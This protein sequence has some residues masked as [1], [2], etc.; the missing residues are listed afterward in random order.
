[1][2]LL[3]FSVLFALLSPG[4]VAQDV[5]QPYFC[6]TPGVELTYS[7]YDGDGDFDGSFSMLVIDCIGDM[8]KGSVKYSHK[9]FDD[10]NKPLFNGKEL[11]MDV[12]LDKGETFSKMYE[13]KKAIKVQDVFS[14]GDASSL[15]L[16]MFVGMK[17]RDGE[18]VVQV[19]NI[20]STVK[21]SNRKVTS[22]DLITTDAG[23]YECFKIEE[24]QTNTV[25]GFSK[26]W[27]VKTWYAKNMGCVKQETYRKGKLISSQIL[28]KYKMI[29]SK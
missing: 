11:I 16:E 27:D 8:T 5:V 26:E 6:A 14:K 24:H 25:M 15:P 3:Y 2:K 10:D 28:T 9:F 19:N 18:I 29:K 20:K 13:L 22:K 21:V 12:Y 1:M 23:S 17:I 4:F 7:N